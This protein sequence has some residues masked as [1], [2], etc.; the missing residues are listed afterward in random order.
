M[1]LTNAQTVNTGTLPQRPKPNARL[2]KTRIKGGNPLRVGEG[3]DYIMT[4]GAIAG[5]NAVFC[6]RWGRNWPFWILY[7]HNSA[8]LAESG[9]LTSK[10]PI[11]M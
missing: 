8:C 5:G 1:A 2:N 3:D 10:S 11:F 7:L 9:K 4:G 6:N